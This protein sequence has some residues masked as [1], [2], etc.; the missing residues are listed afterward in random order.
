MIR[1][2]SVS[3]FV[4][5]LFFAFF[6]INTYSQKSRCLD[7]QALTLTDNGLECINVETASLG[8]DASCPITHILEGIENDVATCRPLFSAD[9][10][11]GCSPDKI[12][13]FDSSMGF[14]DCTSP[15]NIEPTDPLPTC[16]DNQYLVYEEVSVGNVELTCAQV[17][18]DLG[19]VIKRIIPNCVGDE[20]LTKIENLLTGEDE[21]YCVEINL[22]GPPS[23]DSNFDLKNKGLI[24]SNFFNNRSTITTIGSTPYAL[25]AGYIQEDEGGFRII[26]LS[27]IDNPTTVATVRNGTGGFTNLEGAEGIT[28]TTIDGIEYALV[29][30]KNDRAVQIID[31]SDPINPSWVAGIGGRP[32]ADGDGRPD[33]D[34][35]GNPIYNPF[36]NEL[37]GVIKITTVTIG[38]NTYALAASIFSN[39]VNIINISDPRNPT[40]IKTLTDGVDG[41]QLN[42]PWSIDTITIGTNTY[43]LVTAFK[44]N[45]VQ[46]IDITNPSVPTVT[47]TITNELSETY[48]LKS[49]QGIT[50]TIIDGKSY[51]L[52]ASQY[53]VEVIDI[54][55]PSTPSRESL[56]NQ[57]H[58]ASFGLGEPGIE[59]TA[60]VTIGE[61]PYII[62]TRN[63]NVT[64]NGRVEVINISDPESSNLVDEVESFVRYN[65]PQEITT[66]TI[67]GIPYAFV[68]YSD[69]VRI[70]EVAKENKFLKWDGNKFT[71]VD[72][73][74][75]EPE[76]VPDPPT[77]E[78]AANQILQFTTAN[79]FECVNI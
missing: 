60:I 75:P 4:V 66:A 42:Y 68:S 41:F 46:I 3:L 9:A 26:D 31:I 28:T 65:K 67:G 76:P 77:E 32:D 36:F 47:S 34:G 10:E 43:A 8:L 19:D 24:G 27:N 25:I 50:T 7:N 12:Q 35:D 44:G 30:S 64:I 57:Y 39:T 63:S 11:D 13:Y 15:P 21:F 17:G 78:C 49:P 5:C 38:T 72:M 16:T 51:A 23:C 55:D 54:S 71:C 20:V 61:T 45:T 22:D 1:S 70:L 74:E 79:K 18:E 40:V 29:T 59:E 73:E 62:G 58:D 53:G 56:I 48:G 33:T 69:G 37:N 2:Y 6:T 52:V 14:F